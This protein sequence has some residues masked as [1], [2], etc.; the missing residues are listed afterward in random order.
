MNKLI[1]FL[2]ATLGS[3]A[4]WSLGELR[5]VT[6]AFALG[7]VGTVLGLYLSRRLVARLL[8]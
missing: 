5:D 4:G 1:G 7:V 3:W 2:G 8:S 6:W